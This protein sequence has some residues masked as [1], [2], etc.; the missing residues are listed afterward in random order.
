MT[1]S[2]ITPPVQSPLHAP[3]TSTLALPA[4]RPPQSHRSPITEFKRSQSDPVFS[5]A[6]NRNP[7][8]AMQ[9]A[10]NALRTWRLG[11]PA[12]VPAARRVKLPAV[13]ADGFALDHIAASV[14]CGLARR[15]RIE[16][17]ARDG[18]HSP[19]RPFW[20]GAVVHED[21]WDFQRGAVIPLELLQGTFRDKKL[22]LSGKQSKDHTLIVSVCLSRLARSV[23]PGS[24]HAPVL[25]DRT[26]S[27]AAGSILP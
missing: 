3:S 14:A 22:P 8:G 4:Q 2:T 15:T 10:R 1:R 7:R 12:V 21:A 13:G 17:N 5:A 18:I 25:R 23:I 6:K 24:R 16:I 11:K 27:G 20:C 9:A 19:C 26:P